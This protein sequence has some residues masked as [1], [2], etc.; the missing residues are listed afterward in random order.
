MSRLIA[1]F[2]QCEKDNLNSLSF[3]KFPSIFCR[4]FPKIYEFEELI[5][6]AATVSL[7]PL[8]LCRLSRDP[9]K[10]LSSD[11][12]YLIGQEG[13]RMYLGPIA[14]PKAVFFYICQFAIICHVVTSVALLRQF[15]SSFG[16]RA[17]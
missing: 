1:N 4:W 8:V 16:F 15:Y 6:G 11:R 7:L 17:H 3:P 2:E 12:S 10:L 14:R 5:F 13:L 9:E